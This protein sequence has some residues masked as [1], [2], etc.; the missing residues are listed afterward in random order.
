MKYNKIKKLNTGGYK[1][2]LEFTI[3]RKGRFI[4]VCVW[5]CAL[6]ALAVINQLG[7]MK[8]L[9]ET[10]EERSRG[11]ENLNGFD[12]MNIYVQNIFTLFEGESLKT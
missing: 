5:W 3:D 1:Y 11:K 4:D 6:C 2:G 8:E 12:F 7:Q 9:G 10:E